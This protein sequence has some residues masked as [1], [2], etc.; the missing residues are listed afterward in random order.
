MRNGKC[1]LVANSSECMYDLGACLVEDI[2][3]QSGSEKLESMLCTES[4]YNDTICD[5][6][7]FM[8]ACKFDDG[9]CYQQNGKVL[10]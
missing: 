8:P 3:Q 5:F 2:S 1:D 7:N 6:E 10:S 9:D 4:L